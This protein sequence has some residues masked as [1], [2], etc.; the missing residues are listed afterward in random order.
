MD[1]AYGK[2][3]PFSFLYNLVEVVLFFFLVPVQMI[4]K[5]LLNFFRGLKWANQVYLAKPMGSLVSLF[6][7]ERHGEFL[8]GLYN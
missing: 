4:F 1:R 8:T 2:T 5:Q 3:F 7:I 6:E